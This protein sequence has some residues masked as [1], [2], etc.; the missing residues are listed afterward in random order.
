MVYSQNVELHKSYLKYIFDMKKWNLMNK[1]FLISILLLT[2]LLSQAQTKVAAHRGFS[3]IAPE[4]TLIAF[5][6]AIDIG[7]D[8]FELDV[9]KTKDDSLVVIHDY[10][11]N[12]TSSDGLKGKIAEMTYADLVKIKVGAPK[13]FSDK[14]VDA[15]IPTLRE[16]LAIAKGKIKVCIEVKVYGIEEAVL[17]TVNDLKV[18]DQ[19][20]IFSFYHS[21]LAKFREMDNYIPILYLKGKADE[22]TIEQALEIKATAI[23]LG[24][25]TVLTK[26]YLNMAHENGLEVWQWTVNEESKMKELV[27]LGIDGIITNFPDKALGIR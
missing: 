14:Y 15:K 21:V 7:A 24:L 18:N 9:H 8:Y 17:K 10:D 27:S 13:E 1:A 5:Q 3:S 25:G 6:K 22:K 26:E 12:R 4:N 19:V 16:A 2:G 11:V 20:I 23:G